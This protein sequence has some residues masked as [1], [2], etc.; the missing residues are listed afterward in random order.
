MPWFKT[1]AMTL[2]KSAFESSSFEYEIWNFKE[3]NRFADRLK[4]EWVKPSLF[5][6]QQFYYPL[7]DTSLYN[8]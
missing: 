7:K 2:T 6:M 8:C 3:S 5:P 1:W 4:A